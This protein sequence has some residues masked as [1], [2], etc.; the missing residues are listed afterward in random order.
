M[1]D[2]EGNYLLLKMRINLIYVIIKLSKVNS[3]NKVYITYKSMIKEFML[4][5]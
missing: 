5:F 3:K 4:I 1:K 2:K